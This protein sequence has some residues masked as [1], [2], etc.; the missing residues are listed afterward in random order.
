VTSSAETILITGSS[1][2]TGRALA[3]ALIAQGRRVIGVSRGATLP[4]EFEASLTEYDRLLEITRSARADVIVHLAGASAPGHNSATDIYN[5]NVVGTSTLFSVLHNLDHRPRLVLVASSGT[6]YAPPLP[7]EKLRE[8]SP[9]Q[10]INEYGVSKLAVENIC[11]LYSGAMPI[12]VTRPFNY[13][14]PGQPPRFLV[15][16]I[17]KH[18]ADGSDVIK[19]GNLDLFRDISSLR[20][21]VE[22]YLRLI[23]TPPG[24]AVN[25]C[26]GVPT[27]LSSIIE[28]LQDISGRAVDVVINEEFV[29]PGEPEYVVGDCSALDAAIGTWKKQDFRDLLHEMYLSMAD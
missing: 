12:R 8:Y 13:T 20:D 2:F 28:L 23:D 6:V 14:G 21:I 25:L 22:M 29:R 19:L 16:K 3:Q 27:R 17:V 11:H 24:A 7:G 10:P 18:F 15:P 5:S 26:S 4:W 9:L 1:G